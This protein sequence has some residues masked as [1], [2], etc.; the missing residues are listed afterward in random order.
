MRVDA[1]EN[2]TETIEG[3][4]RGG[5]KLGTEQKNVEGSKICGKRK[6]EEKRKTERG[7]GGVGPMKPLARIC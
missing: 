5:R 2:R 3:R 4:G 1:E 6:I 7:S